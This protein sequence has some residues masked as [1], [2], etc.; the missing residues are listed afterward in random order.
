MIER[1]PQIIAPRRINGKLE[2]TASRFFV[3]LALLST[4]YSGLQVL[5]PFKPKLAQNL[6]LVPQPP[7]EIVRAP[8][9]TVDFGPYMADLERHIKR[10]WHSPISVIDRRAVVRFKI[11]ANGQ[12]SDLRL[13]KSSGQADLDQSCLK[14][15]KDAA[16]MRGLPIGAA[17]PVDIEFTFNYRQIHGGG[18]GTFKTL[19][20]ESTE[21]HFWTRSGDSHGRAF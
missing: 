17:D 20:D 14:A 9:D 1:C 3:I 10:C 13:A 6:S 7:S 12:I 15:I 4:T 18:S 16:P 5:L 2:S 19:P 8:G 21:D 11:S